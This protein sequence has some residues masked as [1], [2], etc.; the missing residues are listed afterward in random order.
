MEREDAMRAI[1]HMA[2]YGNNRVKEALD[3]LKA[4]LRAGFVFGARM[5]Y[6]RL[7]R[8]LKALEV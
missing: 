5:K 7:M 1:A 2:A 3:A 8:A 4:D 6:K